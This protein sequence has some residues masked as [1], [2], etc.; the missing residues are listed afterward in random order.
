MKIRKN[1]N[2]N[3]IAIAFSVFYNAVRNAMRNV[4]FIFSVLFEENAMLCPKTNI[5]SLLWALQ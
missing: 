4:C 3:R 5:K 2:P 1:S